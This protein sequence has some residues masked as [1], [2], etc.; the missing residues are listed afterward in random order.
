MKNPDLWYGQL[1]ERNARV[2]RWVMYVWLSM[3]CVCV[4]V[5]VQLPCQ[6]V[7]LHLVPAVQ[8][9]GDVRD[10]RAAQTGGKHAAHQHTH[11]LPMDAFPSSSLRVCV[12]VLLISITR[13]D[14]A[15][16][17]AVPRVFQK[18]KER[19]EEYRRSH[20]SYQFFT[21]AFHTRGLL[22]QWKKPPQLNGG[23]APCTQAT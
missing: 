20:A 12:S 8:Q 9:T 4:C 3:V 21:N 15:A 19:F 16:L 5:C 10:T 18:C 23:M 14:F 11:E 1:A 7:E 22:A 17:H 2:V 6:G 13:Q